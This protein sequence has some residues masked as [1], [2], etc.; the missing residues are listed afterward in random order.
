MYYEHRQIRSSSSF[1]FFFLSEKLIFVFAVCVIKNL[2]KTLKVNLFASPNL[3]NTPRVFD[4]LVGTIPSAPCPFC[5][6]KSNWDQVTFL[7][8]L[9]DL[10]VIIYT[11]L[12]CSPR[13]RFLVAQ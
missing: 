1:T 3:K 10:L 11:F 4:T 8:Y 5:H 12:I 6:P 13:F 2:E 7:V 9:S